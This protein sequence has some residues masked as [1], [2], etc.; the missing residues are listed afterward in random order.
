MPFK[1]TCAVEERI[2]LFLAYDTKAYSITELCRRYGVSRETFYVWQRRRE[3]GDA[4]WFDELSRAPKSRPQ[5]SSDEVRAAVIAMRQRFPRFG[6]KKVLAKLAAETPGID[7]PAASTIG[8]MLKREGLVAARVRGRKPVDQGQIIAGASAPNGE[9]AIDFKGWF[10]TASGARCDP[11]TVTDTASRMLLELRHI[12]M[13]YAAVRCALERLFD[14]AGLPDALRSDNGSPFGSIGPGGLSKLSVWLLRLGIDV[15]Y[16]PP[17][18]PQHNGR[19]ERMHKTLKAETSAPP[20]ATLEE[21]QQRFDTFRH[22]YNAERPHEAIGQVAPATLWHPS[23]RRFPAVVPAPWYDANHRIRRVRQQ[24]TIKW[25]GAELFIGEALADETIGLAE[26][27]C[28]GHL[29]RFCNRDLGV[30]DVSRRFTRFAP[31]RARLGRKDDA[32]GDSGT[33]SE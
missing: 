22:Y 9:W 33:I 15:R 6:P 32:P 18:A 20:A 16:I 27:E 31:P 21:Q 1:G 24:G 8:D 7:W 13:T 30:I 29:V 4:R 26:L 25:L 12:D 11:L 14:H 5:A 10:R 19:H 17:G 28:G 2:A 23:A 3:A